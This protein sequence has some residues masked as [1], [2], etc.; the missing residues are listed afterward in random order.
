MTNLGNQVANRSHNNFNIIRL[1]LA[2]LVIFSHSFP[3]ALGNGPAGEDPDPFNRWTHLQVSFG[4]MAVNCFFFISGFLITASWLHSKSLP[5]YFLKRVLRIYPGFIA[6][7][8]FSAVVVWAFCPEFRAAMTH[9]AEWLCQWLRDLLFLN[10]DSISHLGVFAGNPVPRAANGSLWTISIEF[11]CYFS[12]LILGLLGL[13]KR[14]R[15]LLVVVAAG[16]ANCLLDLWH[17]NNRYDQFFICF[18]AGV[19]AWLWREKL[20][21]SHWLAG[22]CLLVLLVTSRFAP[23][24]SV[25]FPVA[26]GYCLLWLAYGPRL[27]LSGWAE[28]TDLSY[29]TYLYAF[30]VQQLLATMAA[31]RHPWMIFLFASP[32]TFLCAWLS[33]NLIEQPFLALK[34]R[35]PQKPLDVFPTALDA[36][37]QTAPLLR[38]AT[39][40]SLRRVN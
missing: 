10:T 11:S 34:R 9:P 14:R 31:L 8:G 24:F 5:D 19:L 13:F 35:S 40:R 22:G 1:L 2:W 36:P 23:W 21:F 37:P 25:V 3:L 30:P 29:G 33:W 6:A 28:K 16:Y 27:L 12:V 4:T 15:W 39:F 18:A 26:G 17:G 32:I 38:G 7:M 20:P